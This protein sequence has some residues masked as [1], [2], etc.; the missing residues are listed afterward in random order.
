MKADISQANDI[1]QLKTQLAKVNNDLQQARLETQNV[2]SQIQA[3][4]NESSQGISGIVQKLPKI[5][6]DALKI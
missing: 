5:I 1:L 6:E 2:M 4:R 3:A